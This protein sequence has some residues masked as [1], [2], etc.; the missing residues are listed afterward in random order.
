VGEVNVRLSERPTVIQIGEALLRRGV[1]K[2]LPMKVGD[3]IVADGSFRLGTCHFLRLPSYDPA[4]SNP[5]NWIISDCFL[6]HPEGDR[7]TR[8]ATLVGRLQLN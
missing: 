3:D 5:S 2:A 8:A 4:L 1:E 6:L 7:I